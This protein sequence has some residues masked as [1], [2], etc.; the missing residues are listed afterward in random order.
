MLAGLARGKPAK[1]TSE[2]PG[3]QPTGPK[4]VAPP[5]APTKTTNPSSQGSRNPKDHKGI[6]PS[7]PQKRPL[8][9]T[10]AFLQLSSRL[11]N[12]HPWIK[13]HL[14]TIDRTKLSKKLLKEVDKIDQN[15][16][17]TTSKGGK[18]YAT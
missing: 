16:L 17:L 15:L 3:N 18:V 8:A 4:P 14:K 6:A 5:R 11:P 7:G 13:E 2:Q 9:E 12:N 10:L 1:T